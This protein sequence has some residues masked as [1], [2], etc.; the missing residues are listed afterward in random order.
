MKISNVS[1]TAGPDVKFASGPAGHIAYRDIDGD[2]LP[3]ILVHGIN[4][5]SGVWSRLVP[6]LPERRVIVFDLRGHGR[7]HHNPPFEI[8]DYLVDLTSVVAAAGVDHF[9]LAGVSLGGMIACLFAQQSSQLVQ[10]I[11]CFGSG[12]AGRHPDLDGAMRRLRALGVGPYFEAS[13]ERMAL[14]PGVDRDVRDLVVKF[15]ID[16]REDSEMVE[17]VTR[18][19]F[20]TDISNRLRPNGRPVL[21]A[22][23]ELDDTCTPEVGRALAV[24][25]AGQLTIVPAA[26]HVLPLEAPATCASLIAG[27]VGPVTLNETGVAL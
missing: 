18:S 4:M 20:N 5:S 21:V 17:A 6:L 12:L 27:M 13:L 16:G 11:V 2:G 7:S 3:I 1:M 15:A 9:Q 23:G 25:V 10:S 14:P 22:N 8:D 24:A 26:G 19:G